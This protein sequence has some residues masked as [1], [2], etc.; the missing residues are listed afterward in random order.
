VLMLAAVRRLMFVG[1][2]LRVGGIVGLRLFLE[3]GEDIVVMVHFQ[4]ALVLSLQFLH[5]SGSNNSIIYSYIRI[6][7]ICSNNDG[8]IPIILQVPTYL[9]ND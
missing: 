1:F 3:G 5:C 6:G 2:G 7:I 4:F 9:H 8:L